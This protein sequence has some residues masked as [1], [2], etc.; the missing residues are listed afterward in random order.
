MNKTASGGSESV[1]GA[2]LVTAL[3]ADIESCTLAP[4]AGIQQSSGVRSDRQRPCVQDTS[5]QVFVI[6][7]LVRLTSDVPV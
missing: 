7:A 5:V 4:A 6:V 3:E 2:A 1:A